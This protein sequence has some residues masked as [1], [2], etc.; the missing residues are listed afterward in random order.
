MSYLHQVTIIIYLNII[1]IHQVTNQDPLL[2]EALTIII[3][4]IIIT[5]VFLVMEI[6]LKNLIN[7]YL[8]EFIIMVLPGKKEIK[9]KLIT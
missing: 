5:W 1:L 8:I 7:R 6:P 9:R 4:I 3:V 2:L